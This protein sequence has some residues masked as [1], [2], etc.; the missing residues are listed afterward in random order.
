MFSDDDESDIAWL[1]H[2]QVRKHFKHK[3]KKKNA[4]K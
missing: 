3:M 4:T 1:L 2:V